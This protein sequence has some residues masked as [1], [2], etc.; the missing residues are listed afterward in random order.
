LLGWPVARSNGKTT[1]DKQALFAVR[2]FELKQRTV[3][4]DAA[5]GAYLMCL[6]CVCSDCSWCDICRV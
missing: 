6:C 5:V 1:G 2:L 3:P 4:I